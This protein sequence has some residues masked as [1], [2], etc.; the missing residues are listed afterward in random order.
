MRTKVIDD[1]TLRIIDEEKKSLCN[2]ML[3][4]NYFINEGGKKKKKERIWELND[5]GNNQFVNREMK[6]ERLCER[7]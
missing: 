4:D 1:K 7:M 6:K 5:G 3:G 2:L